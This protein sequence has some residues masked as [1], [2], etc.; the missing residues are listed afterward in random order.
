MHGDT[1]YDLARIKIQDEIGTAERQRRGRIARGASAPDAIAF[2]KQ[3]RGAAVR[4]IHG[5]GATPV[6]QAHGDA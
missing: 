6:R 5:R 4:V 1:M 3:L 2:V